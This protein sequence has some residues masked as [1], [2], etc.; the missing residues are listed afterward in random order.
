LGRR[1]RDRR[2]AADSGPGAPGR[3]LD[4]CRPR[5]APGALREP[6]FPRLTPPSGCGVDPPRARGAGPP[7]GPAAAGGRGARRVIHRVAR[8][9]RRLLFRPHL[10]LLLFGS[11]SLISGWLW[12]GTGLFLGRV[13][14]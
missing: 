6:L 3:C 10:A 4:L 9:P 1:R 2:R 7:A 12:F 11:L 8:L 14:V 13:S 5:D